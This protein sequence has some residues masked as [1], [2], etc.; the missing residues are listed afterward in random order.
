[1]ENLCGVGS[2]FGLGL[3]PQ[4]GKITD[5]FVRMRGEL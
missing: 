1:M 3:V 5:G 2:I 4:G